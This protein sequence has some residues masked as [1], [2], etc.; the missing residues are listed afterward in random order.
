MTTHKNEI[1]IR[2]AVFGHSNLEVC[3][4]SGCGAEVKSAEAIEELRATLNSLF[5][6]RILVR[7]Y[8]LA[9]PE[10]A[11]HFADV[12]HGAQDRNLPFP[13]VAING[14]IVLA[15]PVSVDAILRKIGELSAGD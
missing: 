14:D 1:P 2:I 8:D 4:I 11:E 7:H 12:L 15:G 3:L 6:S 13:L 10:L 5:G 9:Q